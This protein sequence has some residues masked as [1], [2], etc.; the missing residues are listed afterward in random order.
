[1]KVKDLLPIG[2]VILLNEAEKKLMITGIK[3]TDMTENKTYDYIGVVYPEGKIGDETEF[4]F[5]HEDINNVF[6]KGYEDEERNQFMD[7]LSKFFNEE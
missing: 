4:L 7:R 3:Q 2:S 1:M 5:N 6:F